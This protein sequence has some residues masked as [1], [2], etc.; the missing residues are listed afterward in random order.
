MQPLDLALRIV[1]L[2]LSVIMLMVSVQAWRRVRGRRMTWVMLSFL[3]FAALSAMALI[4]ELTEDAVW[5]IPNL[6]VLVLI[7]IIGTNYLALLKG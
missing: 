1:L 6:V 4:G 2:G 7:L 5:G 3:G